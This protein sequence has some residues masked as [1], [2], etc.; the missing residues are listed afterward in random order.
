[1]WLVVHE[2]LDNLTVD[3]VADGLANL[4]ETVSVLSID[5]RPR[6]VEPINESAVFSIGAAFL[7]APAHAEVSIAE[8][9]HRFELGQEFGAKRS[10]DDVPLVGWIVTGRWSEAFMV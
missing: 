10:F 4:G 7:R 3:H 5:D 8:R 9:Q 2:Q 6:F 1:E